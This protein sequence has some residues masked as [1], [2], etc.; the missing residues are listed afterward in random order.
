[1]LGKLSANAFSSIV[2]NINIFL[3]YS[4]YFN[5]VSERIKK[6]KH[7]KLDERAGEFEIIYVASMEQAPIHIH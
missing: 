3:K 7:D 2:E 6:K 4:K 1:M 5:Q